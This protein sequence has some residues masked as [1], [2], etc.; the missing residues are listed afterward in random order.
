YWKLINKTID[1]I[2]MLIYDMSVHEKHHIL[3]LDNNGIHICF[4]LI[5][6]LG[7]FL[8]FFKR[9]L[10]YLYGKRSGRFE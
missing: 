10:F 4:A 7:R 8:M 5:G 2:M 9:W 3:T 6:I 1:K